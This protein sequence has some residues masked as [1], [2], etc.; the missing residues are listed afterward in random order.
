[1]CVMSKGQTG[2]W[3]LIIFILIGLGA[4]FAAGA[5]RLAGRHSTDNGTVVI[6]GTE[7]PPVPSLD[8]QRV[9]LGEQ[10]YRQYCAS[11]HGANLEGASDWKITLPNGSL[12]PPPHDSTGHTWHHP[13]QLLVSIIL[14][15]GE[16]VYDGTMPAFG[17]KLTREESEI[18]LDFFKSRW[19]KEKREYQ[20][21][22]TVTDAR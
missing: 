19:G 6:N 5:L 14:D 2:W 11:C 3:K 7:V 9:T 15:G 10:L 17:E 8:P 12:P 4:L 16:K 18:I 20:W 13:D 22:M 21:W 1:M